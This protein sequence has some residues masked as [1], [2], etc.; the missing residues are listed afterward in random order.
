MLGLADKG[1]QRRLFAALL[2]GDP[3]ALIDGV[4]KQYALGVE[5][6]ALVRSLM[7]LAHRATVAQ[8]GRSGADAPTAEERQAIEQWAE[9]LSPAQLHRL[10]QLL[11]KGYEEVRIAP[12]PLVAAQMALLR[13]MHAADMPDPGELARRLE[14]RAA[15]PAP[16]ADGSAS[17][18]SAPETAALDWG[19]LVEQVDRANQPLAANLMRLQVRVVELAPGLLRFSRDRQFTGEVAPQLRDALLAATGTRWKVEE[20]PEGGAPSLVEQD[21]AAEAAAAA[22]LRGPPLVKAALEAFPEAELVEEGAD[23]SGGDRSWGRR[24][25]D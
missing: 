25:Q 9:R 21:Q 23:G 4:E 24:A 5:P 1:A 19:A 16:M 13:V 3:A 7:D 6:L 14:Q 17:S 8:V 10:W 11:L 12:D 18:P 22:E 15:D 2:E 20:L